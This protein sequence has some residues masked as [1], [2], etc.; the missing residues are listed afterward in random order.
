M[1]LVYINDINE[2]IT[3]SVRLFA[4]D[5]VVYRTI[6]MLQDSEKLQE[7]LH[8]WTSKWQM[9]INVDKCAVLHCTH[10]L[11]PIQYAYQLLGHFL[12]VKKLHTYLGIGILTMPCHGHHMC[13]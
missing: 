7:D 4:D 6:T 12:D 11:T 1:F 8:Q 3:S 10:S 5:C 13:K 2:S 9:K